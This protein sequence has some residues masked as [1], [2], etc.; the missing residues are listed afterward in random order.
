MLLHYPVYLKV[1]LWKSN[2]AIGHP[3]INVFFVNGIA[4]FKFYTWG[5][6]NC[7][8]QIQAQ[9]KPEVLQ[10]RWMAFSL[11]VSVMAIVLSCFDLPVN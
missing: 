1:T 3:Q 5:I 11:L 4:I 8:G 10:R 9:I 6:F 7:D 2:M